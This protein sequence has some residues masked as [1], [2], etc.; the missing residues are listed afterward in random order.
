VVVVGPCSIHDPEAGLE[1]ARRYDGE[2][3]AEHL[4]AMLE[5]LD[6]SRH[7]LIETIDLHRNPEIWAR[8][9]GEW[10]LRFPVE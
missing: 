5:Y 10:R 7:Q 2:F 8:D 9:G 6:M 4:D 3:P 1:Y